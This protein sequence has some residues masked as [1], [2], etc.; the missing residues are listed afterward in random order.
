MR[1]WNGPSNF[2]E[3]N[4]P[5]FLPYLWGIETYRILQG[6]GYGAGFYPTYEALKHKTAPMSASTTRPFLPYL[7]GIETLYKILRVGR[8][9]IRF[10]PT[11]EAL[12]PLNELFFFDLLVEFLPYLWGIETDNPVSIETVSDLVFTLPMRHW[13]GGVLWTAILIPASFYPTYEALKL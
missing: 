7:W 8:K 6:V 10:Y 12:K 3:C 5:T 4:H 9:Y 13:N 2:P 11:Y 1:H